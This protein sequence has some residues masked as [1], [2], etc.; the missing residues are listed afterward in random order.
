M[1]AHFK[2][3]VLAARGRKIHKGAAGSGS[4]TEIDSG[5][6]GAGRYTFF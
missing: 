6:T 1:S 4:W 5:R 2:G 3:N